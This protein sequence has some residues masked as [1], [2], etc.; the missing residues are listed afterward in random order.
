MDIN[1]N[2]HLTIKF[3]VILSIF[4]IITQISSPLLDKIINNFSS[5]NGVFF[6]LFIN[7]LVLRISFELYDNLEENLYEFAKKLIKVILLVVILILLK[8][9]YIKK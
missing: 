7:S 8:K 5:F 1:K 2:I 9:F 4:T 3:F 6:K